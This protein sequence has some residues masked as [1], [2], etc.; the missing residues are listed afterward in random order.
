MN[1]S[2]KEVKEIVLRDV[3]PVLR[4]KLGNHV[5]VE[6]FTT[7]ILLPPGENYGSM[8]L[9]VTVQVRNEITGKKEDL[10]LIAKMLPPTEFQRLIFNSLET[11]KKEVFMYETIMP[12]YNKV[13]LEAGIKQN[14]LFDVVPKFYGFRLSS[15]PNVELN[16]DAVILLDNLKNKGY[17]TGERTIGY[18]LKHSE[19]AIENLA[20]FHAL[21]MAVKLK[22]PEIF[23]VFKSRAKPLKVE[24]NP[25]EV[26]GSI[27]KKI[28]EHPEMNCYV[29]KCYNNMKDML[30]KD[31]WVDI[32]REPWMT[33]IHGDFWV[34]NILF[35]D[36][37]NGQPDDVK[38]IDFQ[39]YMYASSLRDLLFF[40]F[41]SVRTDIIGEQFEGLM[42]LY[43]D[44]LLS[45]LQQ[46]ECDIS[47]FSKEG[48]R[49]KLAE[50]ASHE[51]LHLCVMAKILTL[52]VKE[53][54]FTY[55]KLHNFLID[56]DGN[57]EFVERLLKI[58]LY[59]SKHDW[60]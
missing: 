21:G 26:I 27:M 56:Y 29:D 7:E 43:Y 46:L 44:T 11:I 59:F 19:M 10:H 48:F 18:D 45:R 4:Q 50:D 38:F 34:N 20:R 12:T 36:D 54:N 33:I 6:N 23:E 14:D 40:M 41:A 49:E 51:F 35:H 39:I 60:I 3:E 2:D 37:E 58:V 32:P 47:G 9:K 42:D 31:F 52:D 57:Q 25:E 17:Y 5:T 28:K 24:G 55:D 1:D 13:E 8:I 53:S 16:D 22:K 30:M 15:Q